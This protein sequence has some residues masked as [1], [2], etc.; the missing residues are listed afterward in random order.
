MSGCATN[1]ARKERFIEEK[2]N[3]DTSREEC[4]G[5]FIECVFIYPLIESIVVF[6][7]ESI[8]YMVSVKEPYELPCWDKRR[9][10]EC[11][12]IEKWRT[13]NRLGPSYDAPIPIQLQF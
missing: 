8:D 3:I 11:T 7:F 13:C 1:E 5:S 9:E 4:D 6:S 12:P 10:N 2:C